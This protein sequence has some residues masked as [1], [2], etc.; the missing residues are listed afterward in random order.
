[1]LELTFSELLP[2]T[3]RI[4]FMGLFEFY[5]QACNLELLRHQCDLNYCRATAVQNVLIDLQ[6]VALYTLQE[7]IHAVFFPERRALGS[8]YNGGIV[9]PFPPVPVVSYFSLV[10]FL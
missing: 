10:L 3:E 1:M 5:L 8:G 4:N 7:N 6:I 9:L 2:L